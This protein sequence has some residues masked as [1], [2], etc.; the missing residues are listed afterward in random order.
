MSTT[1]RP[2]S[3]RADALAHYDGE[4]SYNFKL[5]ESKNRARVHPIFTICK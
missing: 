1:M 2:N 5:H 4:R 3:L